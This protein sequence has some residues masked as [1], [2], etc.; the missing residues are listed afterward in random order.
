M[1][2]LQACFDPNGNIFVAEWVNT[3]RITR[4]RKV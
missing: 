3:G 4:L 1:S 2:V